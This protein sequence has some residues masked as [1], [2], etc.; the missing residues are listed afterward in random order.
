MML[1]EFDSSSPTSPQAMPIS[2]YLKGLRDRIGHDLVMLTAVSISVFDKKNRLLL[3]K[4]TETGLWMLPG[5]AI[6][7]NEH[8]A[9]A[10]VRE[11]HEETGLLVE[12]NAI[13]GAFG[14]PEFL[15]K[16]PNG[17][18]AY[19]ITIA[20]RAALV[21]GALVPNDG[22]MSALQFFSSK[23]CEMIHLEPASLVIARQAFAP[24]SSTYF[25]PATWRPGAA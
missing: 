9:D 23:E 21:G 7:P 5:G 6:D 17:D 3:G 12:P 10:A 4:N 16:Y 24:S 8:P 22:E 20:F 19:Y 2:A 25:R 11:C 13:I 1:L 14:G 18:L 15:V